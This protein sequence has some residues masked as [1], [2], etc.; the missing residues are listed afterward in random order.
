MEE[1]FSQSPTSQYRSV[2]GARARG[3]GVK[4]SIFPFFLSPLTFNRT[5]LSHLPAG[6][7]PQ[8]KITESA[9]TDKMMRPNLR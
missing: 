6:K 8:N 1:I 2:K 9:A 3:K 4:T 5:V 7:D